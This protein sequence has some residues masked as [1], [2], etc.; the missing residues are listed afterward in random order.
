MIDVSINKACCINLIIP[1]ENEYYNMFDEYLNFEN[2]N[3]TIEKRRTIINWVKNRTLCYVESKKINS[4]PEV[5][6][7]KLGN[8]S[9]KVHIMWYTG[10]EK[11]TTM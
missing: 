4:E 5:A 1:K 7:V 6:V 10:N 3:D 8:G 11:H 2:I 9:I